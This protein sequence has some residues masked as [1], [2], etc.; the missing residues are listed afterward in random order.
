MTVQTCTRC[1]ASSPDDAQ[2][3]ANC[4]ADLSQW[5][6]T[7]VAL[8]QMQ[9]N[10]RVSAIR[11]LIQGDCCPN[12]RTAFG[13]YEKDRV[14]KLPHPGCSHENGCRCFYAPILNQLYP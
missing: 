9:A 4:K 14:P 5:S 10:P 12:C 11:I 13:A 7:S 6:E 3:C 8:K 2:T 1:S